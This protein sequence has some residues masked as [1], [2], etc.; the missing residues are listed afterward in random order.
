MRIPV[1][2]AAGLTATVWILTATP[3][4]AQ[5]GV[6]YDG[7]DPGPGF[8]P[9]QALGLFVG[10]PLLVLV[11]ALLGVYGPGWVRSRDAE[12]ASDAPTL[13]ITSPAGS[14][15]APHGPGALPAAPTD[16]EERGGAGARW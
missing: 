1:I 12:A 5:S 16:H 13:W 10:I 15:T 14:M 9:L 8:T 2:G 6:V 11:V 7:D 3:A 4:L